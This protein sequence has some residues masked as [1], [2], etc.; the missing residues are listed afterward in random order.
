M[1]DTN[2]TRPPLVANPHLD[3]RDALGDRSRPDPTRIAPIEKQSAVRAAAERP[4]EE[5]LAELERLSR[6]LLGNSRLSIQREAESGDFVYLMIDTDTGET[7]RRWPPETR[8]DLVEY[9]RTFKA[10]LVNKTA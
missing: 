10:G 7:V 4:S 3:A 8:Q 1:A 6:D 5:V 2:Y 9:L